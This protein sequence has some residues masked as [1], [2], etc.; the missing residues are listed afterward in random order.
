MKTRMR[1]KDLQGA[2]TLQVAMVVTSTDWSSNGNPPS[3][4]SQPVGAL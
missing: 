1:M 2:A 4:C 3:A